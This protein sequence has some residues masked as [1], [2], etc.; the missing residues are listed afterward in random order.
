MSGN[1]GDLSDAVVMSCL[2]EEETNTFE[3]L[4][5]VGSGLRTVIGEL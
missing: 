4:G 2:R 1:P 5:K 3:A